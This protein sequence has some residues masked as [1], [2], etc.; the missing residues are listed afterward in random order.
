L[1]SRPRIAVGT[2]YIKFNGP[3]SQNANQTHANQKVRYKVAIKPANS[4][5]SFAVGECRFSLELEPWRN[6]RITGS[7]GHFQNAD[8]KT[9]KKILLEVI[10]NKWFRPK[11]TSQSLLVLVDHH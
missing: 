8:K 9:T 7:A 10:E 11:V 1:R 6:W 5:A 3:V 4:H 2:P